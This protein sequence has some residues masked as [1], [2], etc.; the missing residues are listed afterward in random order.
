MENVVT[1]E[2]WLRRGSQRAAALQALRKPMPASELH[3][4]AQRINPHIQ[5]RD[6]WLILPQLVEHRLVICLTP[7]QA[8]GKLYALTP[9]GR[10]LTEQAFGLRPPAPDD[11]VDWRRYSWVVCARVRRLTLDGLARVTERDG[12]G[13]T[14]TEVRKFLRDEFPVGLNPVI[15]SLKALTVKGLVRLAGRTADHRQCY[16]LT[17]AGKRLHAQLRR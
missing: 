10:S 14:A 12:Q 3:R 2:K 15:R 5:L 13:H 11:G 4:E 1:L 16:A 9:L 6:L 7:Q 17:P 8:N